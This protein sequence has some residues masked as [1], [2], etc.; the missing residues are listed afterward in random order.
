[1]KLNLVQIQTT[2][3]CNGKCIICPY[4]GSWYDKNPGIM[5]DDLYTTI[6]NKINPLFLSNG[7]FCPYLCNEPFAD[8]KI[9]GRTKE[10]IE[11]LNFP[12]VE[13]STNLVLPSKGQID[14]LLELYEAN[15]WRGRIMVSHHG[16]TQT[17]YERIM[18]LKY[19]V[20]QKNLAYLLKKAD[21]RLHVWIH[22]AFQS[23]D[24]KYLLA[25]GIE[26]K[27]YWMNFLVDNDIDNKSVHIYPLPFHNRAGN[28]KLKDWKYNTNPRL[29][30]GCPRVN[31]Q[32]HVVYTG[33]V[34][35]CCCDYQRETV[36]GDL[37]NQS[38]ENIFNSDKWKE[39]KDMVNGKK[40]APADFLCH[41]CQL[42]G[43]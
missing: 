25:S 19:G 5:S 14:Q 20:A 7:K 26:I 8:K 21:K 9:I 12:Y 23:H 37:N 13:F 6:L 15:E 18:G 29:L 38:I 30:N 28:V 17:A 40:P 16:M 22:T 42:P 39:Y 33:E 24:G 32:L 34:I 31:G 3:H 36:V 1:M 11:I 41:R 2:S 27:R 10:A 43:A 35:L 4:R